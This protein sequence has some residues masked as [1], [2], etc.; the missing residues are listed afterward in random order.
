M[1][2]DKNDTKQPRSFPQLYNALFVGSLTHDPASVSSDDLHPAMLRLRETT[3]GEFGNIV[4]ANIGEF[5][6]RQDTC[7]SESRTHNLPRASARPNY[8]WFSQNNVI[9]GPGSAF[10]IR[11]GC[12]GLSKA[13]TSSWPLV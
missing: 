1:D 11:A 13:D 9:D 6:V 5:G 4:M 3:G 7:G 10:D 8:L 2:S 12:N